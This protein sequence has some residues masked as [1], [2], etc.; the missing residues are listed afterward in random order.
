MGVCPGVKQTKH[1]LSA[2]ADVKAFSDVMLVQFMEW[3][4]LFLQKKQRNACLLGLRAGLLALA[5]LGCGELE[6]LRSI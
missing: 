4:S 5:P 3:C 2:R 1:N 6:R